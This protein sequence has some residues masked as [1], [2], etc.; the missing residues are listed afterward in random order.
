MGL[1][2]II[3]KLRVWGL[4]GVRNYLCREWA[5]RK[6]RRDLLKCAAEDEG[7]EPVKGITLIGE[8]KQGASNLKTNRDFAYALRDAGIPF[9]TYSVDWASTIPKEEYEGILT[10]REEFK[11]HRYTHIVEM[12]R[13]PLPREKVPRR[14]RIAFW[15]GEQGMF[16]VWPFLKGKDPLIAMSDFNAESFRKNEDGAKVYKI[17]YPLRPIDFELPSAAEVRARF[18]IGEKDFVVFYNFDF[19]SYHRKNPLAAVRAFAAALG[20]RADAKLVFKVQRA[21][22]YREELEEVKSAAEGAGIGAQLVVI[23]EYLPHQMLYGLTAA[24]DVYL[25]LH[26]GEGFGIGMAEAMMM[27]KCVV[28]T[29]WSANTEFVKAGVAFPIGYRLVPIR[30]GEYFESMKEWAEADVGEAAAVLKRLYE[31]P[32]E[33]A[34]VGAKAKEFIAAHFSVENFRASV[35]AFLEDV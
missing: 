31:R 27:G 10:P 22:R 15:E 4:S 2:N 21:A 28:A 9:Q 1:G 16:E 26:R 18:G 14:A 6:A 25:S 35:E 17:V 19:G 11:L 32:E 8:F 34:A 13:S 23:E 33:R 29:D 20:G 12:F 7:V 3:R 30:A 24:C 5:W